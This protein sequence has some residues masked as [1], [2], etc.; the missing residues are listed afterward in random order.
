MDIVPAID[1]LLSWLRA[2]R[3]TWRREA[4]DRSKKARASLLE[5]EDRLKRQYP[6]G[7]PE[8]AVRGN[9]FSYTN[10]LL[11][12]VVQTPGKDGLPKT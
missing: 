11:L 6:D 8:A 2:R 9:L 12:Y 1:F 10:D 3:T 7:T 5:W 4:I